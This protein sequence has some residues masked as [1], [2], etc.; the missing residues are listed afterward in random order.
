MGAYVVVL[1]ATPGGHCPVLAAD[2]PIV[3][4][5][6][7]RLENARLIRLKTRERVIHLPVTVVPSWFIR[8]SPVGL[9]LVP[10]VPAG[11]IAAG[12]FNPAVSNRIES[13]RV[14]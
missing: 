7:H 6:E 2:I 3:T 8:H 13:F 14:V 10:L 4:I 9:D 1:A 12:I 11:G 5:K